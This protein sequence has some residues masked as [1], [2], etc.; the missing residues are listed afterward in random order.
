MQ[1]GVSA[2]IVI[3]TMFALIVALKMAD[4]KPGSRQRSHNL[5][6]AVAGTIVVGLLA[7]GLWLHT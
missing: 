1:N 6:L 4:G 5:W 3:A 7:C 2:P